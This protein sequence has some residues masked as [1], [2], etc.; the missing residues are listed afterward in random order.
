MRKKLTSTP[1]PDRL[2]AWMQRAGWT[3]A[4]VADYLGVSQAQVSHLV[5]GTRRPSLALATR[6]EH[7]AKIPATAWVTAPPDKATV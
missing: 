5:L 7:M 4:M 2:R 1:T 3:H 6:I